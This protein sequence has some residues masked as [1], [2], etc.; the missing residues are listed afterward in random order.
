MNINQVSAQSFTALPAQTRKLIPISEYKGSFLKLTKED[1][2]KINSIRK[3]ITKLE[4]EHYDLSKYVAYAKH[5]SREFQ[6]KI[7]FIEQCI[8]SLNEQIRDVKASR[9]RKQAEAI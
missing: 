4:L 8:Q 1:N 3:E 2:D 9:L 6:D 7:Y 5:I